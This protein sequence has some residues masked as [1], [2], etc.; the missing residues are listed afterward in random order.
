MSAIADS[1]PEPLPAPGRYRIEPLLTEVRFRTRRLFGLGSVRGNV[2]VNEGDIN[3]GAPLGETTVNVVLDA[4]SFSSGSHRRDSEVCSAKFLDAATFPEIVFTSSLVDQSDGD[5]V[6]VGVLTA[7]GTSA[8]VD[9]VVSQINTPLG[10]G[11]AV[12][13]SAKIDRY[14]H[15]I[16]SARGMAGRWLA[17]DITAVATQ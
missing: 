5:W 1:A 7:H 12:H 8:P 11:L 3:I 13:A 17:I 16:T 10:G 14:A 4:S 9:V 2:S 6:A 15:G